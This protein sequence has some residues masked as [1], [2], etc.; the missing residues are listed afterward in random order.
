MEPH[1]NRHFYS[2]VL[3]ALC[4]MK[5]KDCFVIMKYRSILLLILLF[6][7]YTTADI[8]KCKVNGKIEFSDQECGGDKVELKNIN[9]SMPV[10][11]YPAPKIFSHW[12]EGS[13]LDR[14]FDRL[15]GYAPGKNYFEK[16][17]WLNYIEGRWNTE[18]KMAEF[19]VSTGK[20]PKASSWWWHF[21]QDK[22]TFSK[23]QDT[24]E[25]MGAK[26]VFSQDFELPNGVRKYQAVW[27]KLANDA[28]NK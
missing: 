2:T 18:T 22:A 9:S 6:S 20:Q 14:Y 10:S 25:E 16:G 17:N 3:P 5:F 12:M 19:R 4:E 24:Y 26:L 23:H 11:D 7:Q 28:H 21:N 13:K 8:Y 1:K 15:N 27:H